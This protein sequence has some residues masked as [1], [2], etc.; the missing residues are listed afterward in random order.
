MNILDGLMIELRI[1]SHIDQDKVLRPSWAA[2][3]PPPERL[4]K[5]G[6]FSRKFLVFKTIG[7][8]EDLKNRPLS[9]EDRP[10]CFLVG[11][12]RA[13]RI[14]AFAVIL[15]LQDLGLDKLAWTSL[16]QENLRGLLDSLGIG[17][18]EAAEEREVRAGLGDPGRATRLHGGRGSG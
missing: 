7:D 2:K 1:V 4:R 11:R 10:S 9:Q 6:D 3:E 18:I 14:P 5:V 17:V 15:G 12:N 13:Q 16:I 8:P